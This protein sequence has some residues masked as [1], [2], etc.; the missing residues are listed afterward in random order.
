MTKKWKYYEKRIYDSDVAVFHPRN[1][2]QIV[3]PISDFE[4]DF[5]VW[6]T[7]KK[8]KNVG[9]ISNISII[10]LSKKKRKNIHTF[11]IMR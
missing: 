9:H 2:V 4:Y 1:E 6:G 11:K 7:D 3:T 5:E 8:V 10:N